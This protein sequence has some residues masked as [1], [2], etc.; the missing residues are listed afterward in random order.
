MNKTFYIG[1]FVGSV[2]GAAT[3]DLYYQDDKADI[4]AI[5]EAVEYRCTR[6][7]ESCKNDYELCDVL[8]NDMR[9]RLG[10]ICDIKLRKTAMG[11]TDSIRLIEE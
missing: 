6:K 1:V 4:E 7:V 5:V 10:E 8:L 2:M 11:I 9:S 3:H